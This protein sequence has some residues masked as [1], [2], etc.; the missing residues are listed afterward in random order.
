MHNIDIDMYFAKWLS[1]RHSV[2]T[3]NCVE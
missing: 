2:L 1:V 3:A